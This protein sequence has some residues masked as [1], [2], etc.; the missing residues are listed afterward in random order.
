MSYSPTVYLASMVTPRLR[1]R[2]SSRAAFAFPIAEGAMLRSYI[3]TR[4]GSS[5]KY[6]TS[7][8]EE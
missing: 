4:Q 5:S 2:D 1:A 8:G 6:S 7:R 3:M